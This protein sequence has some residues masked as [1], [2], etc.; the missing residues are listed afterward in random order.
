MKNT[1]L[2]P[3]ILVAL[4]SCSDPVRERENINNNNYRNQNSID[5]PSLVGT[6]PDGKK[7]YVIRLVNPRLMNSTTYYDHLDHYVYLI[8]SDGTNFD[9]NVQTIN[10]QE[11]QGKTSQNIAEVI[12]NGKVYVERQ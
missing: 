1:R 3:I 11:P 12:I 9:S 5:N 2:L 6:L 4:C 8:S 10:Y 7:L